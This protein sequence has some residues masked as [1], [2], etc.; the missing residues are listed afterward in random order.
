MK[1]AGYIFLAILLAILFYVSVERFTVTVT[2]ADAAT[3]PMMMGGPMSMQGPMGGPMP[4]SAMS[5]TSTFAAPVDLMS[6]PPE[7]L[8]PP[9]PEA[10]QPVLP[11]PPTPPTA[12]APPE[13][14]SRLDELVKQEQAAQAEF[15]TAIVYARG[16]QEQFNQIRNNDTA[17]VLN[18]ARR[19]VDVADQKLLGIQNELAALRR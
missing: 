8:A 13:A 3:P 14:T 1:T 9:L 17:E 12:V 6:K 11:T 5:T 18:N 15:E 19:T 4:T 2:G 16:A 10:L 7:S